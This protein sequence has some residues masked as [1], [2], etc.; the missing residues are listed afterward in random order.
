MKPIS[1]TSARLSTSAAALTLLA[2]ISVAPA[3]YAEPQTKAFRQA[4]PAGQDEVRLANLAGRI[5]IVR[6]AGRETVVETTVFAETSSAAETQRLLQG[7]KWVKSHDKK[8]RAEWALSYPVE[9]YRSYSYPTRKKDGDSELP[10]FLSFL[11]D[12]GQSVTTY[13]GERVRIYNAKR[14]SVP[15]LYANLRIT[16]PAGANLAVRNVVGPV[17]G[18]DLEGTLSVDTGS[19]GVQ[20]TSHTGQLLVD[21]GS[22]DVILGSARGE[23]TI[24]TGSGDVIVKRFVGNG[25]IDTGSGDV[26]VQKISAGRLAID[27]G[28]GDVSLQ[29]GV[30]GKLVAETG[31][32]GVRVIAVELEELAADTGSG[33]ITV[34]TSL[35]KARRVTAE[36]GS[37]DIRIRAGANAQFT[38]ASDQSSGDLQVGYADAVLRKEGRKVVGAKRGDGRTEIRL[39]TGSGDCSITPKDQAP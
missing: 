4:F 24:D 26:T 12:M 39:D 31:S 23:T 37:G 34:Q 38:L 11:E 1:R 35:A 10:A 20:I 15:T 29:D 2:G 16:L 9:K 36:T 33:D 30:A 17:R 6:G 18:G 27:T 28:S 21:T 13:R 22:G 7:M 14:A 32:G 5:E 8:G 19:G 3:L 25:S